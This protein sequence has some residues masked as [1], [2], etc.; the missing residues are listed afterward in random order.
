MIHVVRTKSKLHERFKNVKFT[1]ENEEG[2]NRRLAGEG[3]FLCKNA[4]R[5][6]CFQQPP[7]PPPPSPT[8]EG[9]AEKEEGE[10]EEK[11]EEEEEQQQQQRQEEEE[12]GVEED[13][14]NKK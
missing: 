2:Q 1:W 14:E 13:V 8:E 7:P 9:E 3:I 5:V 6:Y 12:G 4:L 11:E 10:E